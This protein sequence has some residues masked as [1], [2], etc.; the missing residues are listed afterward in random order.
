MKNFII[1]MLFGSALGVGAIS[2]MWHIGERAE[3]V[4]D[5]RE[6]EW[7]AFSMQHHC[8]VTKTPTFFD[9]FTTWQCEGFEVRR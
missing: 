9:G 5:K 7:R 8:R 4:N 6:Q 2:F 3:A 1:F